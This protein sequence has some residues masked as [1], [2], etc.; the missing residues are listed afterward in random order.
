[1]R[2][3]LAHMGGYHIAIVTLD[4]HSAG[5]VAR[6]KARLAEDFPGL[7]ISVHAAAEWGESPQ[8]LTDAK[9][10]V[11]RADMIVANLLFLE[12]HVK[13]ILPDLRAAR[14]RVD[15]F[16]GV[17]ADA[18][19][20]KLTKLGKLDMSAPQSGMMKLMKKLRGSSKPSSEDGAKKM[21]MLRRLPRMLKL[22]PGK[23][24]DLRS[25]FLM[26]Q[27]WLG[28]SDDNFEAMIRYLMSRYAGPEALRGG[29]APEPLEYPEVGLY[30]PDL[31]ARITT[32][33][34]DIPGPANPVATVGMLMMR[35]YI[36]AGD[37]AHYDAA[38]RT[39]EE[40]GIRVLPAFAGGLDG[41]P[42]I[43]TYFKDA[44]G[45]KIDTLVSLTG[46]SLVGGPAYN[47]SDSA[48]AVLKALDVPYVAAH[49]LEFQTLGQWAEANQ[50]LGPIETTMLIALPELDGAVC[51]TVFGGRH[52]EGGCDG[53]AHR[54][55]PQGTDKAMAPCP[56]RIESLSEKVLRLARLRR[57]TRAEAKIGIVLFGF[58][59][60]AGAAGTA[61]Y[62]D[63]FESLFNVMHAMK[64]RGYTIGPPSSVTELR[65]AVLEGNAAQ[66]GQDA[67]VADH[68][69]ADTI[70]RSTPPLKAVEAVWGPAP[71]R[72][73][74]DGRGVFVLGQHFG[75]VFVGLQPA[76]GWEGDPMRLLFEGS[77]APTH[78]F[79]TFYLWLRNTYQADALL[80]F[81][82]HGALEFM[83]GKQAG[84]GARDWPDRLIGEM[85]NVYLYA[86]NNP[87]EA[88]LAKRRSGA[89]TVTHLTPPLAQS[90]LYK[91]LQALKESLTRWRSMK[92][93]DPR[94]DELHALIVEEAEAVDMAG[95]D[96]EALWL[97]LL[98]TED[99]L[100]PEGLHIL[101]REI[102]PN[103]RADYLALMADQ[104]DAAQAHAAEMLDNGG[105]MAGLMAALEARFVV[106][107]PG[108]DLIRSADILPTGRNIHAFDPFRMPTAFAC[109]D[110]A[111][112]AQMLLDTHQSLPR[113]VAL[114]LWGSD[115]IK[116][117]GAPLAQAL[118]LMGA[119]PRMD[120]F[121]RIS[122]AD[123]IPLEE[124]G[125]PR[126]DVVM[127]LSGI[128]RDLLPLQ[129]R[130]LAEAAFKAASAN[131]PLEMN[132]IRAHA[133]AY[134][135]EHGCDLETAAL[136]VF[137]N[138]EGAY[139]SNVN[140]LV[141]SSAFGD[142]DELAD[143]YQ[144][145]KSFAYGANGKAAA[146]PA[147]LQATLAK[148]EV[149]YQNLES[150]ELGV[151]TVDHYFDTLG[152]ISRAVKRARGEEA[153]VYISDQ[154]RGAGKV[155]TLSDQ[156]ALET[157][158]R[159][160][161]PK[162]FE[163][164][165]KHG[166]QGVKQIEAQVTN[167][168]GWSAT[169][170]KVEPW[171]YQRLSETFVLDPEMRARLAA[172]N[173][174]ASSRMANRLLEAHDRAY[175]QP[176]AETLAALEAAADQLEDRMEGVAAE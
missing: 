108:G 57:K 111:R 50:G 27:Y 98:E 151:T 99:A 133:L 39:F 112:Q 65:A 155:R 24:Q 20:V 167:T 176:D 174:T 4:A 85:P 62:L 64:D 11:A 136:R 35:S 107:V 3:E 36:L 29:V 42:A 8:S 28:G 172:L 33:P 127:T 34:A 61:A 168:M 14:E 140:Q 150:V 75:N 40:K 74:S 1:M 170:G 121:G 169:T 165:L 82:M 166:A 45:A 95:R 19:I 13:H 79:T 109:R 124:L 72:I 44:T 106:P 49:P 96:P 51:P 17:I 143:A 58:P 30:H 54:C 69:S 70:V 131:E 114:V 16:V 5:P 53:C 102:T 68:V 101:G 6:A 92:A 37:T 91:G 138:A 15:A 48:V 118:A 149:A 156:V 175:W 43:E 78:A 160:L 22:I 125:R 73:Q 9:R 63:V 161:N 38:I 71:G 26:M 123:L 115:N 159:S 163:G 148:V 139:G 135:D 12:E 83:P 41:R 153:A 47:D 147:L 52:G 46:F 60:N 77:F 119:V 129:T 146:N 97:A 110:G 116:S 21:R 105:E 130:M 126:I 128:F 84:L 100:I 88:S 89:V 2:D 173:P 120:S 80:H 164:M 144:S 7:E 18:E 137:S 132:F 113:S 87:S 117:D 158:S 152:G 59:P 23:A 94:R 104:D 141:E 142:E 90:G 157:R 10:A 32:D 81:G 171:I 122:G 103:V 154:T 31:G 162:W 76:F 134:Q 86:A 93:D 25:W 145:R 56:E 67:N 66:Y 55:R